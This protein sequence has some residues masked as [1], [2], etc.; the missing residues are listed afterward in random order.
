MGRRRGL[1][2]GAVFLSSISPGRGAST[3]DVFSC[4]CTQTRAEGFFPPWEG[5]LLPAADVGAPEGGGTAPKEA[6]RL[7]PPSGSAPNPPPPSSPLRFADR[8]RSRQPARLSGAS[9]GRPRV[10]AAAGLCKPGV[11]RGRGQMRAC[12]CKLQPFSGGL[13]SPKRETGGKQEGADDSV[14]S[15][16]ETC[17]VD[18]VDECV[19][20]TGR[21]GGGRAGRSVGCSLASVFVVVP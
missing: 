19:M 14:M 11:A 18:V 5:Q 10:P 9:I 1:E 17:I 16:G 7:A 12:G 13:C 15:F 21:D 20:L 6:R 3:H 8:S 2:D 4:G